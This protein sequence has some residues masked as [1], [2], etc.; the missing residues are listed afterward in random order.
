MDAPG[1]SQHYLETLLQRVIAR[2]GTA[3]RTV[4]G[5]LTFLRAWHA[6]LVPWLSSAMRVRQI[7]RAN[8]AVAVSNVPDN[9]GLEA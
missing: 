6:G 8:P 3:D 4:M 2:V 5:D 7:Y 1:Q 9:P